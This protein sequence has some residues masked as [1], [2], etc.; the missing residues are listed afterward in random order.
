MHTK[1]NLHHTKQNKENMAV[2]VQKFLW[3]LESLASTGGEAGGIFFGAVD[4]GFRISGDVIKGNRQVR[5]DCVNVQSA[6]FWCMEFMVF[7]IHAIFTQRPGCVRFSSDVCKLT[8]AMERSTKL[9]LAILL[10]LLSHSLSV[11]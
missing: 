4:W 7:V 5:V 6:L 2:S 9:S 8:V 10:S 11:R 3:A 1:R